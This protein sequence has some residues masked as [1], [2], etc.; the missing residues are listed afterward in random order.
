VLA[1][2]SKVPNFPIANN[3]FSRVFSVIDAKLARGEK[4]KL[5][6][7]RIQ[8]QHTWI[9]EICLLALNKTGINN[10]IEA[11][12]TLSS[13]ALIVELSKE[14]FYSKIPEQVIELYS[15][16]YDIVLKQHKAIPSQS[17]L[18]KKRG[19]TKESEAKEE[20]LSTQVVPDIKLVG[21]VTRSFIALNDI[22]GALK[23]LQAVSREGLEYDPSS[24]SLL[25]SDLAGK[26]FV[27][28]I[29]IFLNFDLSKNI[30]TRD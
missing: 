19:I 23:L 22:K 9:K 12:S 21:V 11:K 25:V 20:I 26:E 3:P 1:F 13:I 4:K 7:N 28:N 5:R 2:H 27:P 14:L 24:K 18:K 15:L 30:L 10:Q 17:T 16:Y 6:T 8:G 29:I